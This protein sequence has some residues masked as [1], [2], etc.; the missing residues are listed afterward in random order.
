[1]AKRKSNR[2]PRKTLSKLI[3]FVTV[4]AYCGGRTADSVYSSKESL[5]DA[6]SEGTIVYEVR[7]VKKYKLVEQ[8]AKL[9]EQKM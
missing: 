3:F 9:Q 6:E 8:S 4:D 2:S 1:M 5:L 7:A